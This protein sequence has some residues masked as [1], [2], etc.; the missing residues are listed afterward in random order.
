MKAK[1]LALLLVFLFLG[2]NYHAT[3]INGNFTVTYQYGAFSRYLLPVTDKDD[4]EKLKSKFLSGLQMEKL[5]SNYSIDLIMMRPGGLK[6]N[7][8]IGINVYRIEIGDNGINT[9]KT[10]GLSKAVALINPEWYEANFKEA[11]STNTRQLN[12][13]EFFFIERKALINTNDV[14]ELIG[15]TS[16]KNQLYVFELYAKESKYEKYAKALYSTLETLS[17]DQKYIDM[18]MKENQAGFFTGLWHGALWLFRWGYSWFHYYDL[19]PDQHTGFGY[20][21]GFIIGF[22][23]FG[24][25]LNMFGGD[26]EGSN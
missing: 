25:G 4:I 2:C 26:K 15:I 17:F 19:W 12:N 23:F 8:K 21:I 18:F 10:K 24:G 3:G 6:K 13:R 22:I 14:K 7:K 9:I 1:H 16:E 5:E 11:L 20:V